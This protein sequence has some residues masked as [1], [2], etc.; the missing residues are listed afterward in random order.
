MSLDDVIGEFVDKVGW[1]VLVFV[2][3]LI[4]LVLAYEVPELVVTASA[5]L[6]FPPVAMLVFFFT[7][8]ILD[9]KKRH[10]P[11]SSQP[12]QTELPV[13]WQRNAAFAFFGLL[14]VAFAMWTAFVTAC[15]PRAH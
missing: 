9:A 2:A 15:S 1:G 10:N 14:I 3:S 6:L 11:Q 8:L 7:K 12:T 5:I 13:L 4:T